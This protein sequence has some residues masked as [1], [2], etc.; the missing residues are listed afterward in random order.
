MDKRM[1]GRHID[2]AKGYGFEYGD[3]FRRLTART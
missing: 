2:A 3:T 1:R